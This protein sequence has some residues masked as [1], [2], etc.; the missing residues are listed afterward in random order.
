MQPIIIHVYG[1]LNINLPAN[2]KKEVKDLSAKFDAIMRAVAEQNSVIDSL[3]LLVDQ[4]ASDDLSDEET[5]SILKE[6]QS[7]KQVVADSVLRNTRAATVEPSTPTPAPGSLPG[8]TTGNN[9]GGS[10]PTTPTSPNEAGASE[11]GNT[12]ATPGFTPAPGTSDV[13]SGSPTGATGGADT[14]E[15][16]F[17]GT[18]P[19]SNT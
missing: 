13:P 12:S 5:A 2:N 18:T 6:M 8:M 11:P 4:L 3:L 19:P 10:T 15:N 1:T 9:E 16:T 7:K 17:R 14:E